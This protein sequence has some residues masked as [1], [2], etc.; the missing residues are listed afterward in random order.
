MTWQAELRAQS[1]LGPHYPGSPECAAFHQRFIERAQRQGELLGYHERAFVGIWTSPKDETTH[2]MV[3]RGWQDEGALA[4]CKS[5]LRDR[6][7]ERGETLEITLPVADL[8]LRETLACLGL[9]LNAVNLA[10]R[11][12]QAYARLIAAYAPPQ[13]MAGVGLRDLA[14]ADADAILA[15]RERVFGAEPAYNIRANTHD[16]KTRVRAT[17]LRDDWTGLRKVLEVDGE[18]RGL[19]EGFRRPTCPHHQ[20]SASTGL[21]LD[22]SLRNQ[23]LAKLAYRLILEDLLA[24]DIAWIKGT[25]GR[26][27]VMHLGRVMGRGPTGVILRRNHTLPNAWFQD[28]LHPQA[29]SGI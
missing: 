7:P 9:G 6:I 11:V 5:V 13:S 4:W 12:P 22:A 26:R 19:I 24:H 14:P 20:S 18:I 27:S 17:I 3:H 29:T 10:G 28:T 23:G 16:T 8:A 15:L 25:T 2:C 1:F 21:M